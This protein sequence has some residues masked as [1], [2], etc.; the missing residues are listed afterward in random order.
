MQQ[1]SKNRIPFFRKE[2][3]RNI[4]HSSIEKK[5]KKKPYLIETGKKK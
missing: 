3:Y 2:K 4:I 5:P 1:L